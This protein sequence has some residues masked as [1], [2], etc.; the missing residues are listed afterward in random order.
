MHSA[1]TPSGL[2]LELNEEEGQPKQ[3]ENGGC[4]GLVDRTFL[5]LSLLMSLEN[6]HVHTYVL[7]IIQS[8]R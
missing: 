1:P 2:H 3:P 4:Q 8:N 5:T 6:I 7:V